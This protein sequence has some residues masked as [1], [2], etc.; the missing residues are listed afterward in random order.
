MA[1][2][3]TIHEHSAGVIPYRHVEGSS[4]LYLVIHSATV[5]NPSARW[6]FPKGGIERCETARQAAAREFEEETG[7]TAWAFREGFQKTVSYTYVR[8]GQRR[9]KAV[10]YFIAEVFDGSDLTCSQEHMGEAFA[11]WRHWCPLNDP[12]CLQF[13]R[14]PSSR[15]VSCERPSSHCTRISVPRW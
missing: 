5:R 4:L 11:H 13:K 14:R 2:M 7:I 1:A 12:F 8:F 10:T 15:P 9:N 3:R 6:E